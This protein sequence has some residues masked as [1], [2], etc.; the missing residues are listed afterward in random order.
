LRAS[1]TGHDGEGSPHIRNIHPSETRAGLML[2]LVR[3][4]SLHRPVLAMMPLPS[5]ALI[6]ISATTWRCS[7]GGGSRQWNGFTPPTYDGI[8]RFKQYVQLAAFANRLL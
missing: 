2:T 8:T 7:L 6:G 1:L 4:S 5:L 3:S